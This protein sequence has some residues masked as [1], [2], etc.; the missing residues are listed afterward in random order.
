MNKIFTFFQQYDKAFHF[1]AS[2]LVML[3]VALL[4][5][6][7]WV[8]AGI[9]LAGGLAKEL[10]DKFRANGTGFSLADLLADA[11]G[12][13]MGGVIYGITLV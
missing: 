11:A 9:A 5:H 10:Y 8:G 13:A 6:S 7:L 12:I 1:L 4:A 3:V 2:A